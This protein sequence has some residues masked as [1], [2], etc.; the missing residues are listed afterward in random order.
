MIE[1]KPSYQSAK[2]ECENRSGCPVTAISLIR[3]IGPLPV[4]AILFKRIFV[5]FPVICLLTLAVCTLTIST[6]FALAVCA[7]TICPLTRLLSFV[8]GRM[9]L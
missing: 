3:H 5:F 9:R 2:R 7:L 4:C 8:A 1:Q 6:L